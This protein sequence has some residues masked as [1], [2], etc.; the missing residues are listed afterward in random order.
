MDDC[1][2]GMSCLYDKSLDILFFHE[3]NIKE[4]HQTTNNNS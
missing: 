1:I 4:E 2:T 3:G